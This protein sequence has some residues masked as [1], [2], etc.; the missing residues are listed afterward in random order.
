MPRSG[1]AA[2]AVVM[3]LGIH[4]PDLALHHLA[5]GLPQ[6]ERPLALIS[7]HPLTI[8]QCNDAARA[9]GVVPG[10]RLATATALCD[11]LLCHPLPDEAPLL[12]AMAQWAYGLSGQVMLFPPQ[13]LVL[14]V[15]SMLRLFGGLASWLSA[16][17][18][19]LASLGQPAHWALSHTP[20]AAALLARARQPE[21]EARPVTEALASLPLSAWDLPA[22]AEVRLAG[23]GVHDGK[24]LLALP[25]AELGQRFGAELLLYL[26]RLLGQRPDPRPHFQPPEHYQRR[27][28]LMEE[29]ETLA[30]LRF[31]L[32]RLFLELAELL[33]RRQLAAS[34]VQIGLQ[35][36]DR[37]AT[38]LT[39]RAAGPEF[40]AEVWMTLC[41]LQLERLVL[42]EPVIALTLAA[43]VLLP[44]EPESAA[45][46]PGQGPDRA[47]QDLLARLQARLGAERIYSLQSVAEVRPELAQRRCA[48]GAG[49]GEAVVAER[50]LWL[51]PEPA[52]IA[53]DTVT[54]LSGPER[55][56]TGWWD[57]QPVARD[58]F[59]G[60]D[61]EGRRLWLFRDGQGWFVHGGF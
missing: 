32:N 60:L 20:M 48:P 30:V 61:P 36:R 38:E 57:A 18:Q 49:A 56:E 53:R 16:L 37:P 51:L 29:I 22:D 47:A 39:L 1:I 54:L 10:Q 8:Q 24:A 7:G 11:G 3:L 52:P 2:G 23:M 31:P 55:I 45:L 4:F 19:G 34:E 6:S 9:L 33:R 28:E 12:E 44:L 35:H 25:R 58:Y 26:E 13:T 40:R 59:I 43:P 27:L 21:T 14:E 15:S 17:Q 41:Q 42:Y 50:P 46:L 5:R